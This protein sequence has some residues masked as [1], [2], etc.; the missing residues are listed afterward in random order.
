MEETNQHSLCVPSFLEVQGFQ[1]IHERPDIQNREDVT[2][3]YSICIL[4]SPCSCFGEHLLPVGRGFLCLRACQVCR[5]YPAS[6]QKRSNRCKIHNRSL[7]KTCESKVLTEKCLWKHK[8]LRTSS[9][10]LPGGPGGPVGPMWPLGR[11][12][13][14]CYHQD[15]NFGMIHHMDEK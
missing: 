2:E 12:K 13:N 3:T 14:I 15:R 1:G 9:P 10:A 4:F 7:Y 8:C 6:R 5:C 11:R